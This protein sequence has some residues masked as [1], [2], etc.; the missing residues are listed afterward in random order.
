MKRLTKL[1]LVFTAIF[2][3][4]SIA[5]VISVVATTGFRSDLHWGMIMDLGDNFVSDD[6]YVELNDDFLNID[7]RITSSAAVIRRSADSTT[8]VT[9]KTG[10]NRVHLEAEVRDDTLYISTRWARAIGIQWSSG[11]TELIIELPERQYERVAVS[12]TSGS[13]DSKSIQI[14]TDSL[15]VKVTSGDVNLDVL[16]RSEFGVKTTSGTVN[17]NGV[18]GKGNIDITSGNVAV[19]YVEWNDSLRIRTT[20][21]NAEVVLPPESGIRV[22]SRVTSGRVEF[23]FGG[24]SGSFNTISG[25]RFGGDNVQDVDLHLTSGRSRTARSRSSDANQRPAH[26]PRRTVHR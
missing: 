13:V 10:S 8:R 19:R 17:L 23:R 22:N 7:L 16:T 26:Y 21:G 24:D 12:V 25:A 5:F 15:E 4:S 18:S 9:L 3:V 11:K 1:T 20:S 6:R 14:D 2:V